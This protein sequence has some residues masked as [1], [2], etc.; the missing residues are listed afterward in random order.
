MSA[1][2]ARKFGSTLVGYTQ[3]CVVKDNR[4]TGDKG[5]LKMFHEAVRK[6]TR[7]FFS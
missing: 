1:V 4:C 6:A 5:M 3:V 2:E 7:K